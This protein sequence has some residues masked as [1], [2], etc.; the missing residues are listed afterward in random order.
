MTGSSDVC[1][2]DLDHPATQVWKRSC[3]EK[4]AI[5][6]P[7]A[8]TYVSVDFERQT[9]IDA[10]RQSGFKSDE[11]T[12]VSVLDRKSLEVAFLLSPCP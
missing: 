1:S 2:S 3:L 6:I 7:G 4:V 5:P 12:F 11:L 9:L 10:L 8:V